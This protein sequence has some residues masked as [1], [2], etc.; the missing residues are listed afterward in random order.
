M[1][2]MSFKKLRAKHDSDENEVI[3]KIVVYHENELFQLEKTSN[4]KNNRD[5]CGQCALQ[6]RSD[7]CEGTPCPDGFYKKVGTINFNG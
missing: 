6:N 1:K 5:L 7:L 3:S 4:I 2:I